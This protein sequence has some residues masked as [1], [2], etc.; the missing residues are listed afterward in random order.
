MLKLPRMLLGNHTFL[1]KYDFHKNS[2]FLF[3][4]NNCI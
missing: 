3:Q 2:D 4:N 1:N